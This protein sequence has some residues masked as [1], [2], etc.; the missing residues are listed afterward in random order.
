MEQSIDEVTETPEIV[1]L[2]KL[3]E[4]HELLKK[5]NLIPFFAAEMGSR[6][7]DFVFDEG[8]TYAEELA[9]GLHQKM[10]QYGVFGLSANQV[11]LNHRV[12]VVGTETK[13]IAMFNPQ[14]IGYTKETTA[15][16]EA[17]I[18]LPNF[19]L[20]LRR[21]EGIHITYQD[22]TGMMQSAYYAG[23]SARVIQHEADHMEG[24]NFT[25]LASNFKLKHELKKYASKQKKAMR[26]IQRKTK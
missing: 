24:K 26:T 19:S 20:V 15:L 17:C 18:S 23:V 13:R 3:P 9:T 8:S 25:M 7:A 16:E 11:G 2:P 1:S 12:F 10:V 21:P 6:P 4:D 22:E 14:I 5:M